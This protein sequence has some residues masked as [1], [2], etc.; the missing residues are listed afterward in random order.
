MGRIIECELTDKQNH[1]EANPVEQRDT[2]QHAPSSSVRAFCQSG[3]D[4][5]EGSIEYAYLFAH[6]KPEP[7]A[8]RQWLQK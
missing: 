2:V 7:V 5:E 6:K 4:H 8:K 3:L 1:R